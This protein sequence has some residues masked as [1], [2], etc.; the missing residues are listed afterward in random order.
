MNDIKELQKE[1]HDDLQNL[2]RLN[3]EHAANLELN[4]KAK[5]VEVTSLRIFGNLNNVKRVACKK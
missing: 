5:N 1:F 2:V 4:E 3:S